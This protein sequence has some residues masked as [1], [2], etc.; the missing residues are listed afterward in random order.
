MKTFNR[1]QSVIQYSF[2][3]FLTISV[4]VQADPTISIGELDLRSSSNYN[5]KWGVEGRVITAPHWVNGTTMEPVFYPMNKPVNLDAKFFLS[6]SWDSGLQTVW[7]KANS[8]QDLLTIVTSGL[9]NF[10]DTHFT[11]ETQTMQYAG[12][13]TNNKI[14]NVGLSFDWYYSLNGQQ[15]WIYAGT[16]TNPC[17]IVFDTP[18]SP[19]S[20]N[21]IGDLPVYVEMMDAACMAM[22]DA[23]SETEAISKLTIG[24][25]GWMKYDGQHHFTFH[26]FTNTCYLRE[27][28]VMSSYEQGPTEGNDCRDFAAFYNLFAAA[29][30]IDVINLIFHKGDYST[31]YQTRW[32]K[33]AKID[34]CRI[35]WPYHLINA[36]YGGSNVIDASLLLDSDANDGNGWTSPG[37]LANND[38]TI[39]QYVAGLTTD[40]PL[41]C[42]LTD[43]FPAD[44]SETE[45]P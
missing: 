21:G 15:D 34:P 41:Y 25:H 22:E 23:A 7:V 6:E 39:N 43:M 4:S 16:T 29:V 11:I 37:I 44:L 14:G 38:L 13:L 9:I 27:F 3:V 30:G 5:M 31:D 40:I 24:M 10:G 32:V 19:W 12:A 20:T 1:I 45:R 36:I 26:S 18:I 35:T 28:V 2:I 17:Y 8:G 42:Q 33:P